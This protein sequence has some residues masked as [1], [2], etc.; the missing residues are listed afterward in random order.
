MLRLNNRLGAQKG[1]PLIMFF[2]RGRFELDSLTYMGELGRKEP[3]T[4]EIQASLSMQ[5]FAFAGVVLDS[6]EQTPEPPL[7]E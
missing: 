4:K 1:K 2:W 6:I 3:I 5:V 7:K